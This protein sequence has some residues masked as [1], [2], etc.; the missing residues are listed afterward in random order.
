MKSII[1]A[2]VALSG[3]AI[4]QTA[5]WVL[6]GTTATGN[7]A[8]VDL[9]RIK[10]DSYGVRTFTAWWKTSLAKSASV[11]GRSYASSLGLYRIDCERTSL[12][13]L[14]MY[15]YDGKGNP[16]FSEQ[17][18]SGESIAVPDSLGE[19]FVEKVCISEDSISVSKAVVEGPLVTEPIF[20]DAEAR[21]NYLQ[22]LEQ[23]G[24]KLKIQFP[25]SQLRQEFLQTVWYESKRSGIDT[26][27]TL[28]LIETLSQFRKFGVREN[29]A[30]GYMAII[31]SWS[32][33]IGDEDP[34][35]LFALQTNL[36]MGCVIFR[37]Y[38]D[39]RNGD[40]NA[41]LLDYASDSI[42][43]P[44][45]DTQTRQLASQVSVASSRWRE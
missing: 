19:S 42:S 16:V 2:L 30:R 45:N 29:G 38:L 13:T 23:T 1:F 8:F 34:S 28:G 27:L 6:V 15:F 39:R 32:R 9:S 18:R 40:V 44:R 33:R 36:R 12:T 10:R 21:A 26:A 22:W 4:A 5:E 7:K 17:R 24:S 3:S 41:A 20:K 43:L 14:A 25:D 37:H 31:P 11:E 35:K